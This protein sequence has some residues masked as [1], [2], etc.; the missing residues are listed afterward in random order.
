MDHYHTDPKYQPARGE[1]GACKRDLSYI[2]LQNTIVNLQRQTTFAST[3]FYKTTFL[4]LTTYHKYILSPSLR[5][6][7]NLIHELRFNVIQLSAMD[8][9]ALA[10]MKNA[11]KCDT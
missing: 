2:P 1:D 11:A 4:L 9:L 6:G 3:S 10:T 7:K 5:R 8:I